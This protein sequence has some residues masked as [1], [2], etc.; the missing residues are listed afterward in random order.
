MKMFR[1]H[2]FTFLLGILCT[3]QFITVSAQ[4]ELAIP[5][6]Y[7]DNANG[8]AGAKLKTALH[9]IIEVGTRVSYGS[10]TWTAFEKTDKTDDGD[11]WGMY[12][13]E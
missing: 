11:V 3:L 6:G 10:G 1:Q 4:T 13:Y 9:E 12:S 2:T 7:Y 8:L 5:D